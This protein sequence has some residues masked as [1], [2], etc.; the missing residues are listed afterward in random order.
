MVFL[1]NGDLLVGTGG[2]NSP[3]PSTSVYIIPNADNTTGTPGAPKLFAS[4]TDVAGGCD[5]WLGSTNAN[6]IAFTK[7]D[8]A[9]DGYIFVGMECSISR[10]AYKAGDQAASSNP[11]TYIRVRTGTKPAGADVDTHHTTSLL[12]VG[13]TLYAG[14]GSDCNACTETDMTRAAVLKTDINTPSF[15]VVATRFRNPL[16]LAVNPATGAIWAG[17]AGQDCVTYSTKCFS[18]MDNLYKT[19]GHPFEF[20]DPITT[21]GTVAD[22]HWPSCEENQLVVPPESTTTTPSPT[23]MAGSCAG[24]LV[25]PVRAPA[26]STIIGATFYNAP[27]GAKYAFPSGYSGGLFFTMHGSWHEDLNGI[28]VGKPGVA[29]VPISGDAPTNPT[30][31]VVGG[32]GNPFATWAKNA[33]GSPDYFLYGFQDPSGVRY[34]R[35]V[36]LAVGPQGSLFIGD[37]SS[38]PYQIYRIRP[39]FAPASLVRR[40]AAAIRTRP[41]S[42]F[43]LPF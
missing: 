5:Q 11:A 18:A 35:P 27:A 2:G 13:S 24:M 41:P 1:P 21:H 31:L 34:G 22:Y 42:T 32:G 26:Y 15:T 16:A 28:D 9:G 29:F 36:G 40:P 10:I 37:D 39:G 38:S 30:N 33:N 7:T 6:G 25:A 4:V 17:G 3:S 43:G 14:V 8:A 20:I 12:A 19:S 23:P